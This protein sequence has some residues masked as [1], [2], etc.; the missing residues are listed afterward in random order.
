LT[1][2]RLR[3]LAIR[4]PEGVVFSV[5][6]AGPFARFLACAV[7]FAL[8]TAVSMFA[9][10]VLSIFG[11]LSRD[12]AKALATLSYFVVSL[13]YAIALEWGWRGQTV[14]KRL[15]RLRVVDAQGLRLQFHQVVVRNL[16]RY[17][18]RL[19]LLYL[20][21]GVA[22]LISPRSQR[23]GDIAAGTVVARIE[24]TGE[25]D[26]AQA[27][28]DKYNSLRSRP[29]IVA[30]LRQR[31]SPAEA[32]VALRAIMRREQIDPEPRARLFQEFAARFRTLA[33]FPPETV[34]DISDEQFVRNVVDVVFR[35]RG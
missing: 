4:T 1:A 14:G 2:K 6:L 22:A 35:T 30:R 26:L 20:V 24:E 19:P 11:L 31:V 33:D 15:L 18:D 7:D 8:I 5:P 32:S 29:A 34:E 23:L 9:G 3:V 21:G 13:G 16:L 25:P 10:S 12:L 28:G 27:L 17:V